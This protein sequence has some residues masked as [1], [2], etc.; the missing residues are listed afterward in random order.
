MAR[1]VSVFARPVGQSAAP[2]QWSPVVGSG[3]TG[4]PRSTQ[5]PPEAETA[6][7]VKI[8]SLKPGWRKVPESWNRQDDPDNDAGSDCREI[9]YN[10]I[11]AEPALLRRAAADRL[12]TESFSPLPFESDFGG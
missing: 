2:S 6:S 7:R 3:Q 1:G 8:Y 10:T 4:T 11:D 12:T 5:T 9:G